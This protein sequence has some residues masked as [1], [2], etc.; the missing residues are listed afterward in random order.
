VKTKTNL[1][2]E[3]QAARASSNRKPIKIQH[4]DK[5]KIN[6]SMELKQDYNRSIEFIVIIPQLIIE[7]KNKLLAH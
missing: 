3:I 6:F 7:I 2:E 5:R 4:A 1:G